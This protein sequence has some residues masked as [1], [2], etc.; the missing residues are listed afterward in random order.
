[1]SAAGSAAAGRPAASVTASGHDYATSVRVELTLTPGAAGHNS[2]ALWVTT[3][4]LA[5]PLTTVTAVRL[6]CSLPEQ[7]SLNPELAGS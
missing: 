5:T 7:P 2:D 6:E 3:T 4:T 1:M